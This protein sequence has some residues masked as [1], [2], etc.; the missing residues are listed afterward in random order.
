MAIFEER[1]TWPELYA[2]ALLLYITTV[3]IL[4]YCCI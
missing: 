4:L 2:K 3:N 1:E